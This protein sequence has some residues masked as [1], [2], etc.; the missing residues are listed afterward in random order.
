MIHLQTVS[1]YSLRYGTSTPAALVEQAARYQMPAVALTDRDGVAGAIRFGQAALA[2]DVAPI[3]GMD[4]ALEPLMGR[5]MAKRVT[6]VKGGVTRDLNL[7][8]ILLYARGRRGWQSLC[9]LTSLLHANAAERGERGKPVATLEL[10]TPFVQSGDLWVLHGAHSELARVV[11]ARRDDHIAAIVQRWQEVGAHMGIALTSHQGPGDGPLT[12]SHA[13]RM[14]GVAENFQLPALITNAVRYLSPH[15]A[16]VADVLDAIRRLVPLDS[17]HVERSTAEGYF[18]SPDEMVQ[19]VDEIARASGISLRSLIATTMQW[20]DELALGGADLGIGSIHLPEPE[21]VGCTTH[22]QMSAQLR[23]R[24]QAGLNWRYGADADWSKLE[25]RLE[26]ELATVTTLGYESYFLTVADVADMARERGIRVAARGSGAGSLICYLLGISGVEPLRHNLLMERFCSPL[27][28]ALPDI[29]IDVESDRRLEVYDAVFERFAPSGSWPAGNARCAAVSMIDTYR[30]RHAIRDTGAALGLP[31]GEIDALAKSFPHIRARDLRNAMRELPEL[32]SSGLV[33]TLGE[34]GFERWIA[35][36]EKLDGLPRHMAMHPCAVVLSDGGLLDRVP[37]EVSA[38]DYPMVSFDKDDVEAVGLLK[39]DILGVRMQS[40]IAHT[41]NQIAATDGLAVDIDAVPFDDNK[42]FD[43]IRSTHTLGLFQVE[44]PGQRELVGK[45]APETFEDLIID[46]SL[47]RPG[48]VKSDM[49]TPFLK[50]R[51]GWAP[52]QIIHSDLEEILASTQGVV[53]FHEQVIEIIAKMTGCTLA[54]GDEHRRAL[55]DHQGQRHVRQWF[56]DAASRRGYESSVIEQVW[57]V[58]AAFASFGFCKAHAAAFALPTYQSA[59]LKAHYPAAFLAGVLTHDPGMY[60]KRLIVD[61]ARHW[62]I[63][64]LPLDI[65]RSY[66]DYRVERVNQ[67]EDPSPRVQ[68]TSLDLPDGRGYGIRMAFSDVHGMSEGEIESLIAARPYRDLTDFVQRSGVSRP[69]TERLIM[70]G[71]FDSL[72]EIPMPTAITARSKRGITRRD[73]LMHNAELQQW[74]RPKDQLMLEVQPPSLLQSGLPDMTLS[75]RVRAEL[76]VLG[77]D[78]S[79]HVMEFYRAFLKELGVV[80]ASSLHQARARSEFLVAG[81]KVAT[82]T[83]PVRS[84]RRVIFLTLDD[85]TGCADAT[86]FEDA[87]GYASTL[88]HSWMVIV[89]G[90]V[91]RTGPRGVSLRATGCWELTE[92]YRI[93][94]AG[95]MEQVRAMIAAPVNSDQGESDDF[96]ETA[97][98]GA[99]ESRS[100]RPVMTKSKSGGMGRRVL[101]H[102]SGFRLSPYADIKPADSTGTPRKLWH[103]S[104]GSSG[105]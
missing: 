67:G 54:E 63:A 44:S 85:G 52:P 8:R 11:A 41:I 103:S 5:A 64:I 100:T 82:Q 79:C 22:S 10:L 34:S 104:P 20:G 14:A 37:T 50:A 39:L 102:A 26:D 43:L 28:A 70:V 99:A 19:V 61:D 75:E 55:G 84:G 62:G 71:A 9:R 21:V 13:A 72:Y 94:K 35:L 65:H 56:V 87:Q 42:A 88:F 69:V 46:I 96:A 24:C 45:F 16:P 90:V 77:I 7:P 48:P 30:A 81:V 23:A 31:M 86:F 83:P 89:R 95:G 15:D 1:G 68:S 73:L 18:K 101:V 59:W 27:R 29:D 58:L 32:R 40:A 38:Q 4:I 92:L 51:Q 17:R 6:P 36:A 3:M 91:R 53:V 47:F 57:E 93:W 80:P 33:K 49:V 2:A 12:T 60:P 78:A 98:E 76:D 74:Q 66:A 97:I 105:Q 25:Q